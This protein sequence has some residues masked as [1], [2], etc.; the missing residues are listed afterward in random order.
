MRKLL[1]TLLTCS[2]MSWG[3]AALAADGPVITKIKKDGVVRIGHRESSIPF[4]YLDNNKQAVGYAIDICMKIVDSI[5][6]KTGRNDL[7]VEFVPVTPKT[8]IALVANGTIDLECGSTTNSLKRQRQVAFSP[9]TYVTGTRLLV[10]KG[11]GIKDVQ[12]LDGKV[13]AVAQGASNEKALAKAAKAAG[14]T[15]KFLY[16]KDIS[17][18]ILAVSTDRADA[19]TSDDIL[20]FGLIAKSKTPEKFAVTGDLHSYDPYGIMMRRDDVDFQLLVRSE[21]ARLFRTKEIDAIYTK[22]FEPLG[23]PMTDKFK[24][25]RDLQAFN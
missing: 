9:V 13:V 5:K 3:S 15:F 16:T 4:S 22:W 21:L 6:E 20:L 25:A 8:R 18:G 17:E 11:S 1:T 14:V 7:K 12:D 19:L 23:V 10:A 2:L 24:A